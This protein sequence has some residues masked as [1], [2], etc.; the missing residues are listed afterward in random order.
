MWKKDSCHSNSNELGFTC[1]NTR[2]LENM[3][4]LW[5]LKH[6]DMA[7]ESND[8]K[9]IW[10]AFKY[11]FRNSCKRE[12]CWLNQNFLKNNIDATLIKRTFAPA[13][14]DSWKKNPYEWLNGRDISNVMKQYEETYPDF[15]F[16]GPSPINYDT[17]VED[18]ECVWND[19]CHFKLNDYLKRN[20]RVIGIVF[21]IDKHTKP[22]SH[23]IALIINTK[24]KEIYFFDSYGFR[25]HP[26]VNI[27]A[28]EVIRQGN[29]LHGE[30]CY[31]RFSNKIDH[32]LLT[33]S[34]C[35]IYCLYVIIKEIEGE[36][37]HDLVKK[38]IP[39][40]R[41]RK[42]RKLYFNY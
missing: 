34:E 8:S 31:R 42:L 26:K 6:P 17:I 4:K 16:L 1:F 25:I 24:K 27:F 11:I 13:F 32:Q 18:N 38:R 22:G 19:L 36:N 33:D 5:N 35:G 14:P 7:I 39:D 2:S 15:E 10:Q 20:I 3:K 29:L 30:K 37:F 9:E 28:K 21:N 41:I 23:W 40:G 12:S